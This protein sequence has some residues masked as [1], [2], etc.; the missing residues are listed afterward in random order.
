MISI[1]KRVSKGQSKSRVPRATEGIVK[2][3]FDEMIRRQIQF[4]DYAPPPP[5]AKLSVR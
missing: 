1:T 4:A 3:E 5:A 2:S